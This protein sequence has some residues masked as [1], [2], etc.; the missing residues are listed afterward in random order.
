MSLSFS[1]EAGASLAVSVPCCVQWLDESAQVDE[2]IPLRG[3]M[4]PC[5]GEVFWGR[6]RKMMSFLHFSVK[7][8]TFVRDLCL[9]AR[10]KAEGTF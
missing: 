4:S 10:L 1:F 5:G 3:V 7:M 2:K 8:C 6:W 9:V